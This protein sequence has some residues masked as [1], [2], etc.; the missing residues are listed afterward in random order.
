MKKNLWLAIFAAIFISASSWA[1]PSGSVTFGVIS[2]VHQDLQAD[3]GP[4]LQTFIA[5]AHRASPAFIIQLGDLSHSDGA[6]TILAVWNSYTGDRFS[7]FGN[8]DMDHATK[9]QMVAKYNMP[10]P[11]YS[12]DRGGVHFVVLDCNFTKLKDGR[13]VPYDNGNYYVDAASRDLISQE[14]IEWLEADLAATDKPSVIFSH[15]AFD[16]TPGAVPNRHE[17]RQVIHRANKEVKKVIAL[18]CGHHHIDAYTEID[19]VAYFQ[20]NSASY[21][22]REDGQYSNGNMA[23]YKDPLYAFVTIDIDNRQIIVS[24]I[25]S[26][27]LP[28]APTK[29]E[30]GL[31]PGIRNRSVKF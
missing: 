12:F 3:A 26:E 25:E 18:F 6:D 22:W 15:Q 28:P 13:I 31:H 7:V 23:E 10:A 21:N 2:D 30:E 20:I 5:A 11:Y 19:G 14:Q 1:Q 9:E 29:V 16:E 24:G 27:F 4:R 8:H 17:V